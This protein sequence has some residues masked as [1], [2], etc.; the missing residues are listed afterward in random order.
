METKAAPIIL[1]WRVL[2]MSLACIAIACTK[3]VASHQ[4]Y[5]KRQ[6]ANP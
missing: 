1:A 3:G 5:V 6:A 2:G 4:F